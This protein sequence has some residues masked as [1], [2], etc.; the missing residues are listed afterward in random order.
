MTALDEAYRYVDLDKQNNE[1]STNYFKQ[2]F[3]LITT[4]PKYEKSL[5]YKQGLIKKYGLKRENI[6]PIGSTRHSLYCLK[7]TTTNIYYTVNPYIECDPVT[8]EY[9]CDYLFINQNPNEIPCDSTDSTQ[10]DT[11]TYKTTLSNMYNI[12]Y[13]NIVLLGI[14]YNNLYCFFDI[15]TK[16]YY[17][18]N[19]KKEPDTLNYE[20]DYL[21]NNQDPKI[22]MSYSGQDIDP[23][24]K[25]YI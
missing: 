24:T 15:S 11:S 13:D 21:F 3:E 9:V 22:D 16:I 23:D 6:I 8:N 10:C 25:L 18:I 12:N 7:D 14:T 5:I 20:C 1:Y 19:P 17:T 4:I 2:Q